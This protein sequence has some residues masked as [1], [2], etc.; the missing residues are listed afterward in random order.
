MLI[1]VVATSLGVILSVQQEQMLDLNFPILICTFLVLLGVPV[2]VPASLK[3]WVAP[4][5]V[6]INILQALICL[7]LGFCWGSYQGKG[8]YQQ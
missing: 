4:K 5:V 2:I 7:S 3:P 1:F 6:G 8:Y